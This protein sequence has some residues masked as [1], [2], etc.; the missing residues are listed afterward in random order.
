MPEKLWLIEILKMFSDTN[1]N[2]LGQITVFHAQGRE[3]GKTWTH[4]KVEHIYQV[5]IKITH[6]TYI[7][8]GVYTI[9][10]LYNVS[11]LD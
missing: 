10:V 3:K 8:Y 9:P 1:C 6:Y 7:G 4:R 2:P 11:K 5:T